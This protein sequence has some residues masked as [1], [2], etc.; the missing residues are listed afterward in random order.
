MQK[1]SVV[2]LFCG[3]GGLTHGFVK[4]GFHVVAG[5]DIDKTCKYAYE[6]N[7]AAKF[8]EKDIENVTAEEILQLYPEKSIKILVGCAPCQPFSKYSKRKTEDDAWKLLHTFIRLIKEIEPEVISMENVPQLEK[9]PVFHDFVKVLIDLDYYRSWSSV[10]CLDYGV[11]Q[12]RRRLVLFASKFDSI[13]IIKKTHPPKRQRHV[14]DLIKQLE[15]I[16]AGEVSSTDPLHRASGLSALNMKRVMNTPTGGSWKDWSDDLV[17]ECHKRKS[18][19][20]YPSIYGRMKWDEPAP[21]MTTQCHGL[22][23]GRFGHPEQHRAISLREAALL[24]TFPSKYDLVNPDAVFSITTIA[25][26]I[27]NAVPVRLGRIIAKSIRK[28]LEDNG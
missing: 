28:H 26:H 12:R 4:E 18:G 1:C 14:T 5:I 25:R 23:N 3:V 27:G 9:H 10:N 19:K 2:D 8:I 22:G 21:T 16:A 15:P 6:K 13:E 24:Q 17:L 11:P 7:N 20:T